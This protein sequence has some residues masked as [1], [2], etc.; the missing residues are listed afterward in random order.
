[1]SAIS[2]G[3]KRHAGLFALPRCSQLLCDLC[4]A[5]SLSRRGFFSESLPFPGADAACNVL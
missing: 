3:A 1:M 4:S 2:A 5:A